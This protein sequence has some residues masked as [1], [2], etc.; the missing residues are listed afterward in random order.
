MTVLNFEHSGSSLIAT[1]KSLDNF[2]MNFLYYDYQT[3][4][5]LLTKKRKACMGLLIKDRKTCKVLLP[6][7]R[8]TCTVLLT[9]EREVCTV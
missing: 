4:K 1:N 3:V 5:V 6:I 2:N 9:D 7:E 8:E